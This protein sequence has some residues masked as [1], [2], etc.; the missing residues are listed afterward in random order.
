MSKSLV[1]VALVLAI[2][3]CQAR[4]PADGRIGFRFQWL[5]YIQGDDIR[6]TCQAEGPDR[7]RLIYN[8]DFNRDIR[9]FDLYLY[10][11]AGQMEARRWAS[12]A[13]TLVIGGR[14]NAAFDPQETAQVSLTAAQVRDITGALEASGFP[15]PVPVGEVLRSDAHFWV[16]LACVDGVFGIQTWNGD[17]LRDVRFAG[18]LESLDGIVEPLPP[19]QVKDLPPFSGVVAANRREGDPSMLFYEVQVGQ[20]SLRASWRN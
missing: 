1:L 16:G 15:G 8:A 2:A 19:A 13:T 18:L 20:A 9:T 14:I 17:R 10:D 11:G 3:A 12:A 4:G 6:D 5:S 7:V